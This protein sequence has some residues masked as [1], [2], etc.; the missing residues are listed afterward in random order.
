MQ[1]R[2]KFAK[3]PMRAGPNL[4]IFSVFLG[5]VVSSHGAGAND[6]VFIERDMFVLDLTQNV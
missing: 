1:N 4:A 3:K 6:Q 2:L 5:L